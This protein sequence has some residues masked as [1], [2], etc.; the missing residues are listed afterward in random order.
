METVGIFLRRGGGDCVSHG[1]Y[2]KK[3]I[4]SQPNIIKPYLKQT[5]KKKCPRL[6]EMKIFFHHENPY[7]FSVFCLTARNCSNFLPRALFSSI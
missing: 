2:G 6:F 5:V 1:P 7:A 3:A 4:E